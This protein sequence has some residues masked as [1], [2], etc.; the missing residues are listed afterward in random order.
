MILDLTQEIH[1]SSSDD[2]MV[3]KSQV[4]RSVRKTVWKRHG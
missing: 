4:G 3:K 2:L 1:G